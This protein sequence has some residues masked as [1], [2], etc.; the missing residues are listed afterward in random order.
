MARRVACLA[1]LLAFAACNDDEDKLAADAS[2]SPDAGSQRVIDAS[3]TVDGSTPSAFAA[4]L[5]RPGSL[6]MPLGA[7]NCD[8][9][10]P[11]FA[12]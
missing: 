1:L 7:L 10:P 8:L 11:D 9:L 2:V 4:C 3:V 5:D 12:R 6:P